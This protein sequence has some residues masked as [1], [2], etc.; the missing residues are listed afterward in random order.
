MSP[1]KMAFAARISQGGSVALGVRVRGVTSADRKGCL[2]A[3]VVHGIRL[4]TRHAGRTVL[5]VGSVVRQS[6]GPGSAV[7]PA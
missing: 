6:L 5:A 1:I 4:R 2:I 3:P 7:V